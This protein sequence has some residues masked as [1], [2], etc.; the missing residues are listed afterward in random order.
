MA[1]PDEAHSAV[2]AAQKVAQ[3]DYAAFMQETSERLRYQIEFA[4]ATLRNLHFVN[5]GAVIA[6]LTLVGNSAV[7]YD[8][9]AIWWS[10]VWFG[11]GLFFSLA[12]Y[13]GA[14][15]S[16]SYFMNATLAQAWNAQAVSHNLP[17]PHDIM[18]DIKRGDTAFKGGVAFASLSLLMFVVGAFVA[19]G[20]IL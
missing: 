3:A 6:L 12:A 16:Q 13:F 8:P 15:F 20:G 18:P 19:L 7:S 17:E 11:T 1:E 9:R 14:F 2:I 10:F 5:G 4:Q